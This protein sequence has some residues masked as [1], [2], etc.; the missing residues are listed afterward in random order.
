M[1]KEKI[2]KLED[3]ISKKSREVEERNKKI[4]TWESDF[5]TLRVEH[6]KTLDSLK[7][8]QQKYKDLQATLN[9]TEN[10]L[11]EKVKLLEKSRADNQTSSDKIK[12]LKKQL[13][14]KNDEID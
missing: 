12:D 2:R 3:T 5:E 11:S 1:T 10:N 9:S 14:E 7:L 13:Q 8:L 6:E 4:I